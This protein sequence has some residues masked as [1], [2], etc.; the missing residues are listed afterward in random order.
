MSDRINQDPKVWDWRTYILKHGP[1][2]ATYRHVLLTLSCYMDSSGGSCFPSYD[3]LQQA[4]QLGRASLAKYLKRANREGWI[5]T[6]KKQL[7]G[8]AWSRNQYQACIPD[9]V[10]KAVHEVNCEKVAGSS[11]HDEGSSSHDVKAVHEVNST[12]SDN[13]SSFNSDSSRAREKDDSISFDGP[14][15]KQVKQFASMNGIT[16]ALAEKFWLHYQS[17]GW[18]TRHGRPMKWKYKLKKWH[19]EDKKRGKTNGSEK[20]NTDDVASNWRRIREATSRAFG[21]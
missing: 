18:Q 19:L 21:D 8:K 4:T 2:N 10:W 1:A 6:T 13:T 17:D 5:R 7:Q 11:P 20:P 15:L 14:E 9:P 16:E 12:S 3:T